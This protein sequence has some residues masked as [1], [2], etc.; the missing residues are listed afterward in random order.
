MARNYNS[1][2]A[3]HCLGIQFSQ[4]AAVAFISMVTALG[5]RNW[6]KP[7]MPNAENPILEMRK[8]HD[9]LCVIDMKLKQ[10]VW[11]SYSLSTTLIPQEI[12]IFL[13]RFGS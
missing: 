13:L 6:H 12:E 5:R 8:A 4:A 7:A 1:R 10:I 9:A 11:K 3:V 2:P